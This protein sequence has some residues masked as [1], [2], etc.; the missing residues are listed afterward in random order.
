[1]YT[2]LPLS[3]LLLLLSE[4]LDDVAPTSLLLIEEVGGAVMCMAETF[5]LASSRS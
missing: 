3:L 5:S 4:G 2:V 1:M